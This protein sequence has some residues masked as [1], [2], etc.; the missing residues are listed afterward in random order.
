MQKGNIDLKWVK[1]TVLKVTG[2]GSRIKYNGVFFENIS[3]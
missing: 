3:S 1:K 2:L